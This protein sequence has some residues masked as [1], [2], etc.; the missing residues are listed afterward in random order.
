MN[1]RFQNVSGA[2]VAFTDDGIVCHDSQ[3][4]RLFPYGG[5]DSIKVDFIGTLTIVGHIGSVQKTFIYAIPRQQKARLKELVSFANVT[6]KKSPPS[7]V[8]ELEPTRK[9]GEYKMR[10]NVC[11]HIFCYTQED[12]IKNNAQK[13]I[14]ALSKVGAVAAVAGGNKWDLYAQG[15]NARSQREKITD[16]SRCPKCNST[17]ISDVSDDPNAAVKTDKAAVS[18]ADEL[19]KF[20]ELLDM[21]VI[22]QEEFDAKKKQLLGL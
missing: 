16:F 19:K 20:K 5:I 4:H 14:S 11:G 6:R 22:T 21:G 8:I 10:C 13:N 12:I 15:M 9:H 7:D 1:E 3:K 2:T 17:D 18:S